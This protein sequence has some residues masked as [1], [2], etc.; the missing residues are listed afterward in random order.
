MVKKTDYD[1]KVTEIENKL[2]NHNHDKYIDTSEFNKLA[3]DV[4]NARLAQANL[5]TKTD[6]DAKLSSLN[7]KITS[8]KTKH[9]LVENE[10]KKLKA[11]DWSYLIG[12]SHFEEDGVQNYLV[13][14]PLNKVIASTMFHHG[15]LK[16]YQMKLLSH[17]L[18]LI[19]V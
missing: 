11:F 19:I 10:L 6:F 8:N 1:A 17:L 2:N 18:H 9:V 13:F 7:R 14:Q 16:D 15:S 5:I 4:F 12:K 3:A